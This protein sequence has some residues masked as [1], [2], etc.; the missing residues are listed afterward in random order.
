MLY[1]RRLP[2]LWCA[3]TC[4]AVCW[5][6]RNTRISLSLLSVVS[7][8]P[9]DVEIVDKLKLP[10]SLKP[11]HYVLGWYARVCCLFLRALSSNVSCDNDAV[12][13]YTAPC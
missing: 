10:A 4:R 6:Q 9:K 3:Q 7:G 1:A 5:Q 11:G 8:A 13:V 12:V 2:L